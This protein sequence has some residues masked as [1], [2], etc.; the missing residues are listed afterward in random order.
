MWR[1]SLIFD[2]KSITAHIVFLKHQAKI[3]KMNVLNST[4]EH[5]L[6]IAKNITVWLVVVICLGVTLPTALMSISTVLFTIFWLL[7]ADYKV[8]FH[9]IKT[10][11]AAYASVALFFLYALGTLYSSAPWDVRLDFLMKYHKLL[12]IPL[13]M[14][15][16]DSD[17]YRKYALDAFLLSMIIVLI[18][19]YMKW[20]GIVS[21]NE[22]GQ[23]YVVFKA[24]IAHNIL[25]SFAMFMMMSRALKSTG[26]LKLSWIVLSIMACF[27]IMFLVNGRTGQITMLAL[28]ILF[29][30]ETWGRKA[31][32]YWLSLLL[33][34][35]AVYHIAPVFPP[36]RLLEINQEIQQHDHHGNQTSSGTRLEMYQN[37][38]SLIKQH[39]FFGGGTGSLENE[40]A[41]LA[42]DNDL[43][44][45]RVPNPHNQLLLTTQELGILGLICLLWM[46]LMHWKASYQVQ[47]DDAA[48]LLRGLVLTIFIGSLF[49]S[50]LL[51]ATEGK[52][53]CV[54]AG[55]LLSS[56]KQKR[57]AYET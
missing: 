18:I 1:F 49:N 27:N 29:T 37:T 14:S 8:K 51:D 12:L 30:Y 6:R 25:M 32:A 17:K 2:T 11:P 7:S 10:Y 50:L 46:W 35:L 56:Y 33:L 43:S 3:Y 55:V 45:I 53:Y 9:Y 4:R 26:F 15:V 57:S 36:S 41:M 42:K 13:V 28:V 52:F 20:L 48:I 31:F 22:D 47:P 24:R 34:G 19:S 21:H 23:G 54:L 16:M 5:Y 38:I 40:Y 39:P 44:L